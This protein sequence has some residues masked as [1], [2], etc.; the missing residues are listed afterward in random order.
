ML[1]L[2]DKSDDVRAWQNFLNA[3]GERLI[4][5]GN[6]GNLTKAAT[7]RWQG[8]F[9]LDADGIVGPG[10]LAKA[11]EF[12]FQLGSKP[13]KTILVSA[14]HSTVPPRDPGAVGNGHTESYLA[15]ELRDL[16]ADL[17]REKGCKVIED[18]EDGQSQPLKKAIDLAKKAD[19]AVEF[20][21]NAGPPSA[22]G[23]EVL[24]KP[25]H[26]DLAQALAESI[27]AATG[28]VL[29]GERGW[30]SDSSGQHHRLGFC[31]AGGLIVEVCFISSRV[32]MD[33]Y[34]NTKGHVANNLATVLANAVN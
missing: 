31:E 2:N 15:L 29:R 24:A 11:K 21:W 26:K 28:L 8:K 22:T 23:I 10:T 1:K 9:G 17:L 13:G 34:T 18:G 25:K 5:D 20:H 12:G 27:H 14:G 33:R 3:S 4:A 32:D 6:F 30:K 19:V 7:Q 16:V